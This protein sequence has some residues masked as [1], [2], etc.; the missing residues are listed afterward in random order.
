[1]CNQIWLTEQRI[2]KGKE[3]NSHLRFQG[4]FNKESNYCNAYKDKGQEISFSEMIIAIIK[5][6]PKKGQ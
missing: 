5:I 6:H 1:M 2:K 4:V 3:T